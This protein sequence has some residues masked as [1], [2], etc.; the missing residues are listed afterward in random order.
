VPA[1][2]QHHRDEDERMDVAATVLRMLRDHDQATEL[3]SAKD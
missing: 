2:P 1:S 3:T